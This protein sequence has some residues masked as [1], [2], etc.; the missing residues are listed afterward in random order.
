MSCPVP[1]CRKDCKPLPEDAEVLL[2]S[3][4]FLCVCGFTLGSHQEYYYVSGMN[5][6]VLGCDGVFYHL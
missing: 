6:C 2:A 4:L 5:H 1:F 3:H